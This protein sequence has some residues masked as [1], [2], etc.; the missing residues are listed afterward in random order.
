MAIE[1]CSKRKSSS[2][3]PAFHAFDYEYHAQNKNSHD[4]CVASNKDV[5]SYSTS[6]PALAPA[7]ASA[8]L[9]AAQL[10]SGWAVKA[11]TAT[12]KEAAQAPYRCFICEILE[13]N[14]NLR[15]K[16]D[17]ID[18]V[19]V[20]GVIS[21]LSARKNEDVQNK[22][23]ENSETDPWFILDDGT[24][25]ILVAGTCPTILLQLGLQ[26][27][28][29]VDCIGIVHSRVHQNYI[30][31][32]RKGQEA[33]GLHQHQQEKYKKQQEI[34]VKRNSNDNNSNK[35]SS[36][37]IDK[38]SNT[39]DNNSDFHNNRNSDKGTSRNMINDEGQQQKPQQQTKREE[40]VFCI[41]ANT[42]IRVSNNFHNR[43]AVG[44]TNEITTT[45]KSSKKSLHDSAYNDDKITSNNNVLSLEYLRW[46]EIISKQKIKWYGAPSV[47][48]SNDR[49][50]HDVEDGDGMKLVEEDAY[51]EGK[52]DYNNTNS[53]MEN[54][55]YHLI[56]SHAG[57][58]EGISIDDFMI[59]FDLKDINQIKSILQRLQMD[60]LIYENQH[61]KYVPL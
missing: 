30:T 22:N 43:H 49:S 13:N 28:D 51:D 16:N 20:M 48:E 45:N 4:N 35:V 52:C 26:L 56:Q 41:E 57:G 24:G 44:G 23:I 25:C 1:E 50:L 2:I 27:G 33:E 5:F 53:N 11:V 47:M 37:I 15:N 17:K 8:S 61:N 7:S 42:L 58:E 9:P 32:H 14:A 60:G 40:V 31:Q 10:A 29:T 19:R 55:L 36:I 38:F 3:S 18:F 54:Y 12:E 21:F 6:A 39:K 46:M 34:E 59:A